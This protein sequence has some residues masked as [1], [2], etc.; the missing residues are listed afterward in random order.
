MVGYAN[1]AKYCRLNI[2]PARE[3]SFMFQV[4]CSLIK[5]LHYVLSILA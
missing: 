3:I 1:V 5:A 2:L 4:N